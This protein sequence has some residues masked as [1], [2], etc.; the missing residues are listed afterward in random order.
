MRR[1]Q[2]RCT[3]GL[4]SY[5]LKFFDDVRDDGTACA[6][7]MR[8]PK[9]V[10]VEEVTR[11]EIFAADQ[12]SLKVLVDAA[13]RAV[14][15]TPLKSG[16]G[17]LLG[18]ISFHFM[19]PHRPTERELGLMDLWAR[20]TADYLERKRAEELEQFL[21][22]EVQH[23]SNNRLA[24]I[25]AIAHRSLS[26]EYSLADAKAAFEARLTR[27]RAPIGIWQDRVG[28]ASTSLRSPAWSLNHL[29]IDRQFT[30][31]ISS[32]TLS[33]LK[34]SPSHCTSLR[35]TPP[36]MAPCRMKAEG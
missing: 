23:R 1:A 25:Q 8:S 34:T 29:A 15:S 3:A 12:P 31:S 30:A 36:N 20:Q 16:S 26:G 19:T 2:H 22:R 24:V 35:P 10:I 27:W 18:M 4:R 9:R 6:E 5:F 32:S 14:I 7:A 33:T 17:G 21:V 28:V 11:S 13:E